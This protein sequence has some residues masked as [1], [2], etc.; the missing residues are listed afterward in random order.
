MIHRVDPVHRDAMGTIVPEAWLLQLDNQY[1]AAAGMLLRRAWAWLM[2]EVQASTAPEDEALV[3][4]GLE[5]AAILAE[6]SA[7]AEA[8]VA[9]LAFPLV[10]ANRI[11]GAKIKNELGAETLELIRGAINMDSVQLMRKQR[12]GQAEV[13]QIDRLRKMLLA[14]INDVRVVLIKLAERLYVLR[15]GQALSSAKQKVIA[16]EILNIYA[17]LANRLG[18]GQLKWEL[19]DRAFRWLHP[20]TYHDISLRLQQ[21]RIARE[22]FI[23]QVLHELREALAA[24]GV[25]AEVNGRVKH[26]YSIWRKMEK[27]QLSF[28]QLFDVRA[29]R[30]LVKDVASCYR[31]LSVVHEH[32]QPLPEEF[33]DYIAT[34]KANGY[35]SIHTVVLCADSRPMEVQIRTFTM[36]EE[37][38]M[39]FAAHWR[40]KE[41]VRH[42][43]SYE[44]RISWL[45]SLLEWQKELGAGDEQVETLRHKVVDDRIYVFTPE[46]LVID[47]AQGATP[48]DFA[49]HVHTEVGHR[50]RGA[51]VDGKMVPLDTPL[52]TG[53]RVEI[54]TGKESK[55][56]RD[57]LRSDLGYVQTVRARQKIQHWFR[58]L[59]K[60]DN[61]QAGKE[62]FAKELRRLGLKAPDYLALAQHFNVNT[63]EDLWAGIATGDVKLPTVLTY[64]QQQAGLVV[65]SAAETVVLAESKVQL[66]KGDLVIGGVDNLL[67]H[68]AGCCYPVMGDAVLGY[69]TQ[70]RGVT[71]HRSDCANAQILRGRAPERVVS[72]AWGSNSKAQYAVLFNVQVNAHAAHWLR[73]I[74]QLLVQEK[75]LL[76]GVQ[77]QM[78]MLRGISYAQLKIEVRDTAQCQR[79]LQ[80]LAQ[81][82][83]VHQVDRA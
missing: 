69:V 56:S 74:T 81:L 60:E 78:D 45:R 21:K 58:L 32:W 63:P 65:P 17:P 3:M 43:A 49:Y 51:K 46:G 12:E 23:E 40:Y 8:L 1:P 55:P 76:L 16:H 20:N 83:A 4:Q 29:V 24:A 52:Q 44:T 80:C 7:G 54:V 10:A 37:S 75:A 82:P 57:W 73:D 79:L 41:G 13:E 25:T 59:H 66:G 47:L 11:D 5:L 6:L 42:D 31:A 19:E 14:M 68:M 50:C 77:T 53:Q 61:V 27:K 38:E 48:V 67:F 2:A 15:T 36:H 64:L 28:D 30:V 26:I 62:L 39:G 34:P 18:I 70:G 22:A 72:V 33:A 71:V 35:R 9:A